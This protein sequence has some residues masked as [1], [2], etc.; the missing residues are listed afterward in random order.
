M[1]VGG[2]VRGGEG[3]DTVR[4]EKL[5]N[6]GDM[7]VHSVTRLKCE[8]M[9]GQESQHGCRT[10]GL[11]GSRLNSEAVHAGARALEAFGGPRACCVGIDGTA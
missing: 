10:A 3:K 7:D 9:G 6:L 5:F 2:D 8:C 1:N 4:T 11:G